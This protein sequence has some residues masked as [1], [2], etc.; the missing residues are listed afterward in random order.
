[1]NKTEDLIDFAVI[2][3]LFVAVAAL[4]PTIFVLGC[5]GFIF[6]LLVSFISV[7]EKF[8]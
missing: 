3:G 2:A 1:M 5:L 8:V 6:H 7:W 4:M